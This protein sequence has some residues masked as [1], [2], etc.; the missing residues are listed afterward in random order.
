M[1]EPGSRLRAYQAQP[2]KPKHSPA[3]DSRRSQVRVNVMEIQHHCALSPAT[4]VDAGRS[5][6]MTPTR[7]RSAEN[8]HAL[9]A[10]RLHE[11]GG[12]LILK[13]DK[14]VFITE[15]SFFDPW[16]QNIAG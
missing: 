4:I 2:T 11:R 3:A 15:M 12:S 14:D 8:R 1:I 16:Q 10:A 9:L 5:I 6:W 13:N 7:W